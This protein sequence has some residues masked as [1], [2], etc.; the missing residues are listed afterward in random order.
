MFVLLLI[1]AFFNAKAVTGF[2]VSEATAQT[3]TMTVGEVKKY[4]LS[5]NYHNSEWEVIGDNV[6][7]ADPREGTIN[8]QLASNLMTYSE[9]KSTSNYIAIYAI[10]PG[11]CT[12]IRKGFYHSAEYLYPSYLSRIYFQKIEITVTGT[13]PTSMVMQHQLHMG[14][15]ETFNLKPTFVPSG[16]S[17]TLTWYSTNTS[18]A[19]VTSAGIVTAKAVG[20]ATITCISAN[21]L[22]EDCNVIVTP[23][24][25]SSLSLNQ[26]E[27]RM[28]VGDQY[29]F[30]TIVAPDNA[31]YQ[32]VT[33]TSM[34]PDVVSVDAN[35]LVSCLSNGWS[36]ILATTIDGSNLTA[37]CFVQVGAT[38]GGDANGDGIISISDVTWM[39][40]YL[41]NT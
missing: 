4:Y 12:L 38:E 26:Q 23:T 17:S 21:G 33:W 29:Q 39:I 11:K 37:G 32:Q 19:T 16:T 2:Y 41:L 1:P 13:E 6:V 18:V 35:G 22:R 30:S 3:L 25:V 28:D 5:S 9:W 40:D 8:A 24:M 27:L 7:I 36:V 20:D 31:S 10:K 14:I 15:R 34:N